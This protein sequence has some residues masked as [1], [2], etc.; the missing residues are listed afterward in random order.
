MVGRKQ[1]SAQTVVVLG[2]G[3]GGVAAA[4]RLRRRLDRRHRV[5]LVN[6]DSDFSFA[7]SYLWVMSG[8]RRPSQ[9]TR[10]LRSLQR[11]GI[12]VVIGSIDAIDPAGR[13]LTVDGKQL[14][15]DHLVVSLGADMPPTP[16]PAWSRPE[17]PSRPWLGRSNS[18]EP[19]L[20]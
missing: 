6:R 13:T 12:D 15:A 18:D 3:I 7:A 8:Q 17:R 19:S 16:S 20:P 9:I 10:P 5:I 1:S 14:T 11:R 4:N 2:G